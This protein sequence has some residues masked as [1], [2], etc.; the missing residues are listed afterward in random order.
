[1]RLVLPLPKKV[2]L[3]T[4]LTDAKGNK[5]WAVGDTVYYIA[6]RT[7]Y[8]VRKSVVKE[9]RQRGELFIYEIKLKLENGKTLKCE[10]SFSTKEE[11]VGHAIALLEK[12]IA[13]RKKYIEEEEQRMRKEER[14][15][16]VLMKHRQ[17]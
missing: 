4:E 11:A 9:I 13:E 1:M 5:L 14:L 10:N 6:D 16:N 7:T 15:L 8:A 2:I 12:S 3:L 17:K